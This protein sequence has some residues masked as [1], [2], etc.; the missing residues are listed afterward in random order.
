[1]DLRDAVNARKTHER[2]FAREVVVTNAVIVARNGSTEVPNTYDHIW[3]LPLGTGEP[4]AVYNRRVKGNRA[5]MGVQIGFAPNSTILEV[6]RTVVDTIAGV[7]PTAGLETQIHAP[8][9]LVGGDD[10]LYV[11]DRA[12]VILLVYPTGVAGL[13]VKVAPLGYRVGSRWMIFDGH[14]AFDISGHEPAAGLARFVLVGLDRTANALSSVAGATT[15]DSMAILPEFPA[16]PASMIPGTFVRLAGGQ[17]AFEEGDFWEAREFLAG[18]AAG[19]GV[20]LYLYDN[21]V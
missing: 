5:G 13:S 7:E 15:V 21:F 9:H 14:P 4:V 8:S 3:V 16:I 17:T 12:I 18:E 19:P 6:L 11:Y 10:P 20:K 1:M 2:Q